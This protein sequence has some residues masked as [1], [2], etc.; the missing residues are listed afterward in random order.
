ML[1]F[2]IYYLGAP[3]E[4]GAPGDAGEKGEPGPVGPEGKKNCW[5]L[6]RNRMK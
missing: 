3:G 2:R 4:R 1:Q 6:W 5:P